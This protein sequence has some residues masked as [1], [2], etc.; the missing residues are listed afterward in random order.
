[1]AVKVGKE[2]IMND[3]IPPN[4]EAVEYIEVHINSWVEV[5]PGKDWQ[6]VR[7]SVNR[8]LSMLCIRKSYV[9]SF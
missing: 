1:M 6:I 2:N 9:L 8:S 5:G 4:K 7:S 3:T